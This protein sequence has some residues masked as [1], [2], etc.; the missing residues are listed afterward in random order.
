LFFVLRNCFTDQKDVAFIKTLYAIS[1]G[2]YMQLKRAALIPLIALIFTA[3]ALS[4]VTAGVLIAQ[5]NVPAQGHLASGITTNTVNV[6]VFIDP[7]ATTLCTDIDFGNLNSGNIVT[8]T[9]YIKNTGNITETLSMTVTDWNPPTATSSIFLTWDQENAKLQAGAIVPATL[10]L[11]IAADT[12]DISDFN[13][14]IV[15]S[16]SA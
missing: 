4:A 10:T 1:F 14:N 8:K 9:L 3:I 11:N 15:I 6:G 16:G 7:Q 5:Q 12:G 2:K 13:F